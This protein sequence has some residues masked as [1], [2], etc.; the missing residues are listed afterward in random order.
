MGEIVYEGS[1]LKSPALWKFWSG[2]KTRWF[3][4][5][6]GDA[7]GQCRLIYHN[8]EKKTDKAR[9]IDLDDCEQVD[10]YLTF[11][12]NR[13]RP[14]HGGSEF[15]FDIVLPNRKY[16]FIAP[17]EEEMN[18]WVNMLC[19]VCHLEREENANQSEDH[20]MHPPPM[21]APPAVNG[22]LPPIGS[23]LKPPKPPRPSLER[24]RGNNQ[25]PERVISPTIE[26]AAREHLAR[27]KVGKRPQLTLDDRPPA[28]FPLQSSAST[29]NAAA[30]RG[31][32][33]LQE[34]VS[35]PPRP[36]V[37]TQPSADS[38]R[39]DEKAQPP[40]N[41]AQYQAPPA[42]R[43]M[44]RSA[45]MDASS[46]DGE[47]QRRPSDAAAMRIHSSES[48]DFD[49]EHR[50]NSFSSTLNRSHKISQAST[51]SLE[52]VPPAPPRL[53]GRSPSIRQSDETPPVS[54][55]AAQQ[56]TSYDHPPPPDAVFG[57]LPR[58]GSNPR[59]PPGS[60][61]KQFHSLPRPNKQASS[62]KS[63]REINLESRP[64]PPPLPG[65]YPEHSS[66]QNGA[67]H[68]NQD[69]YQNLNSNVSRLSSVPAPG[70]VGYDAPPPVD[71]KA[72]PK[73]LKATSGSGTASSYYYTGGSAVGDNLDVLVP[74]PV[75]P[76]EPRAPSAANSLPPKQSFTRRPKPVIAVRNKGSEKG[77]QSSTAG[78]KPPIPYRSAQNTPELHARNS[79]RNGISN[80]KLNSQILRRHSKSQGDLTVRPTD[81]NLDS[82]SDGSVGADVQNRFIKL[83]YVDVDVT[84]TAPN[85]PMTAGLN[86]KNPPMTAAMVARKIE[87]T[88]IDPERTMAVANATSTSNRRTNQPPPPPDTPTLPLEPVARPRSHSGGAGTLKRFF[89]H[90][91]PATPSAKSSGKS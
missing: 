10:A 16:Y 84:L 46:S 11:G 74:L 65:K 78:K 36:R 27:E 3:V 50:M 29:P 47:Q 9:C 76:P 82:D 39:N 18:R 61:P 90:K 32:E 20:E 55:A 31:Y 85:T 91:Q 41:L 77:S 45:T 71:R 83:N 81:P 5:Q 79:D 89:H 6:S 2:W 35:G 86:A 88:V 80:G 26:N 62:A 42:Q 23:V 28:P 59:S 13:G 33:L 24:S 1:L 40:Q 87:Y 57:S 73:H 67:S 68:P 43:P 52:S 30:V 66:C 21:P 44:Q 72:K 70:G 60:I 14:A 8:S 22:N 53:P 38:L 19:K 56:P 51:I 17:S 75:R 48:T 34:F 25:Q 64:P 63:L 58:K 12:N 49:V 69:V 37:K 7:P 4:L 15:I 54:P